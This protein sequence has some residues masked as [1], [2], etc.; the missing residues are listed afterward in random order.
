MSMTASS[1]PVDLSASGANHSEVEIALRRVAEANAEAA[2]QPRAAAG[3]GLRVGVAAAG[4]VAAG[5]VA[6][7]A[8]ALAS[9]W[10]GA[11]DL[12]P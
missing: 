11:E 2:D 7:A 6:L 1:T 9:S 12:Q 8:A 5:A 4:L 3:G 10:G